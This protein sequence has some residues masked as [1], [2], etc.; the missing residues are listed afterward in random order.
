M[1]FGVEL[2]DNIGEAPATT[3]APDGA[4]PEG[5]AP[6]GA[7]PQT[8]STKTEGTEIH[9][10]RPRKPPSLLDLDK[11][12][13][14]RFEGREWTRDQLR[15]AYLRQ[16]DYS[17]KTQELA[18]TRKFSDNFATDLRAVMK[19]PSLFEQLQRIYPKE[20]VAHAKEVLNDLKGLRPD[21]QSQTAQ[22]K[23]PEFLQLRDEFQALKAERAAQGVEQ[24]QQWLNSTYSTLEKKY[25]YARPKEVTVDAEG[26][27]LGGT[28]ITAEVLEKLF[29]ANDAELKAK[30]DANYKAKIDEQLTIGKKGRDLGPG[31]GVPTSGPKNPRTMK[32]AR[33]AMLADAAA[34]TLRR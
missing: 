4:A 32:E 22:Q 25:P 29:K 15:K 11:Q 7:A 20:Y 10:E 28:K 9:E 19:D 24:V 34:G 6:E 8:I 21:A 31:G 17:R 5:S 33:D 3:G 18:E 23:D 13:R 2:P 30:W 14:F 27:A 16:E 26:M 12:E 1:P